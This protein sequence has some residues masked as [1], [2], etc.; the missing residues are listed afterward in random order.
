MLSQLTLGISQQH[1][2]DTPNRSNRYKKLNKP[3]L[4]QCQVGCNTAIHLVVLMQIFCTSVFTHQVPQ[5]PLA[6]FTTSE[7]PL[8][9]SLMV[10]CWLTFFSC[11]ILRSCSVCSLSCFMWWIVTFM[12]RFSCK[13]PCKLSLDASRSSTACCTKERHL[14]LVS[15]NSNFPR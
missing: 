11:R 10:K 8:L 1:R 12:H 15:M 9:L 2:Y 5:C 14:T 4:Y 13:S 6:K 7:Y 3:L